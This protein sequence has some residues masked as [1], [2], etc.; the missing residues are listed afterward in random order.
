MTRKLLGVIV[1]YIAMTAFVFISYT[2]LYFILGTE[3]TFDPES[4]HVS[5]TW[6]ILTIILSFLAAVLGGFVCMLIAKDKKAAMILAGIVFVLGIIV[7]IPSFGGY[8]EANDKVRENN[9]SNLEAMNEAK[10]PDF[11]LLLTPIIAAV[12]V[13]IGSGLKKN[14]YVEN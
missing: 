5:F 12:G 11:I 4:F 10:Q 8:N 2:L 3:G 14:K 9:L 13:V 6:I 7:A 1:G